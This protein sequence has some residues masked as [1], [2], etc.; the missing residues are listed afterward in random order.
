[1]FQQQIN[2][3]ELPAVLGQKTAMSMAVQSVTNLVADL[4]A[5]NAD[6]TAKVQAL[7]EAYDDRAELLQDF[8]DAYGDPET[9]EDLKKTLAEHREKRKTATVRSFTSDIVD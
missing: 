1:M 2:P 9:E 7:Q 6:L 4:G 5:A 8:I 3:M